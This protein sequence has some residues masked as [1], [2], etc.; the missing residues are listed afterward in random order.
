[1]KKLYCLLLLSVLFNIRSSFAQIDTVANLSAADK[2]YG[3]SKFWSE[4]S[5]NFA[6]FDHAKINWDSTYRAYIPKVLATKNTWEYYRL[7]Q[8][9]CAL[10]KDG[11]TDLGFPVGLLT[12]KSRYKWIYFENFDPKKHNIVRPDQWQLEAIFAKQLDFFGTFQV[13]VKN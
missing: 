5:Y 9:F 13:I 3:L 8:Q 10:L 11:H 6:Y 1:M 7:M 4:V 12:H 2:L